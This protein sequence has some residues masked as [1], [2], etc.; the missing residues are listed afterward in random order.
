MLGARNGLA[1]GVSAAP[2]RSQ[3]R[4]RADARWPHP[5]QFLDDGNR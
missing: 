2:Q 1:P 5:A 3:N 4:A